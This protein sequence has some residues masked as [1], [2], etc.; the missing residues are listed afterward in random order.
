MPHTDHFSGVP[1]NRAGAVIPL[2]ELLAARVSRAYFASTGVLILA[3]NDAGI[4]LDGE[5]RTADNG[6]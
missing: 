2:L 1:S 5:H 6:Y 4:R 3:A